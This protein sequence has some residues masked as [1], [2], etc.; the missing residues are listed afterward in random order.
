MRKNYCVI[1]SPIAHSLSP[2][3]HN[4]L[5]ARYGLECT[6]GRELVTPGTLASFIESIPARH[7]SGFNITMPLK[8]E[9]LPHLHYI[10]PEACDGVNTVVVRPE[11]LYGYSTDAQGFLTALRSAGSD[12]K[13]ANIVFIGAGAVTKLLACD[14]NEKGAKSIAIVNRTPEKAQKIARHINAAHDHLANIGQYLQHCDLLVNTTPLGMSGT[15]SDFE[16]L[17]FLERLPS[18]AAVC[19]LI[20]SPAQTALL[21]SAQARGLKTMNGLGMLIWQAFFSFEKWFRIL[22]DQ[23]DYDAAAQELT[24]LLGQK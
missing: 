16:D 3:I 21:R 18:R 19:D 22:P 17:S 20:Y 8:R 13:D 24:R 15:G 6:Y 10:S 7:I 4:M 14:A 5:Y 23:T 2:A 11:G 1:G 9:I 12:Y